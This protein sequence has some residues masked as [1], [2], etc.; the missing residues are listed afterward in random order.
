LLRALLRDPEQAQLDLRRNPPDATLDL[1]ARGYLGSGLEIGDQLMQCR[2]NPEVVQGRRPEAAGDL[3]Q[4]ADDIGCDLPRLLDRAPVEQAQE[5][6]QVLERLIVEL[7]G[8]QP[9]LVLLGPKKPLGVVANPRLSQAVGLAGRLR[10]LPRHPLL[11]H[12]VADEEG[13]RVDD[14][15]LDQVAGGDA[16]RR[17]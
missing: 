6:D 13:H 2:P 8:E 3:A 11:I 17:P 10:P 7:L 9:A 15:D 4:L 14:Q 12:P 5:V 16:R 1:E